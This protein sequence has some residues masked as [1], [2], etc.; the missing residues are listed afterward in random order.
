MNKEDSADD[1]RN[2]AKDMTRAEL[3][4]AQHLCEIESIL[5]G[6]AFE[7]VTYYLELMEEEE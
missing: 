2:S 1:V 7:V 5:W 4:E 3:Y 6:E